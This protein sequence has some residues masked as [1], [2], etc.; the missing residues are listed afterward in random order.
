MRMKK[1]MSI[2]LALL[3]AAMVIVPLVSADNSNSA[4]TQVMSKGYAISENF[5]PIETARSHATIKIAES[6][7]TGMLDD[8]WSEATISQEP[9]IIYD[10]DGN[11]LFYQFTLTKDGKKIGEILSSGNKV[12]GI[13]IKQFSEPGA[14]DLASRADLAKKITKELY[15]E[16]SVKSTRIVCYNYPAMGVM[17]NI[18]N[19]QT[20]EE[21]SYLYNADSLEI[22]SM[23]KTTRDNGLSVRSYYADIPESAYQERIAN[24][25]REDAYL[26]KIADSAREKSISIRQEISSQ[27]STISMS[28]AMYPSGCSDTLCEMP[29]GFP[30]VDQGSNGWCQA[31]TAWV[32]S[33]YYHPSMTRTL[34]NVASTMQADPVTGA[35]WSNELNYYTNSYQSGGASGGLGKTNSYYRTTNPSLTYEIIRTEILNQHP[36]KVGYNGHSRACIGYSRNPGGDTYYKFSNS[37]LGGYLQWEAAPNPY[38][39]ITGYQTYIIVN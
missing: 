13:S 36:L 29:K 8:V 15:P 18:I 2:L 9:L 25:E 11:P 33:K 10:I 23:E 21:K 38:G 35:T 20:H 1:I 26:S 5:I 14:Y 34:T 3:L 6:V 4:S 39:S 12:A 7:E 28:T 22:I 16:F 24:W 19:P 27:K 32:I 17:V 30:T 31:A 37:Q